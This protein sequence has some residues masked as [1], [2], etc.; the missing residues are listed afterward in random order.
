MNLWTYELMNLFRQ[1][2]IK[3]RLFFLGYND[4]S[5]G[6]IDL[7]SRRPSPAV[8]ACWERRSVLRATN[9]ELANPRRWHR[10]VCYHWPSWIEVCRNES[11]ILILSHSRLPIPIPIYVSVPTS[12][13]LKFPFPSTSQII[14]RSLSCKFPQSVTRS[15]NDSSPSVCKRCA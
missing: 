8:T 1:C 3:D 7:Y 13:R 14:P 9:S 10:T 5:T 15:L 12:A 2:S 11:F 6:T 4:Y